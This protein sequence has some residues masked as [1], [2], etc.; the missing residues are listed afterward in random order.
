M[1]RRTIPFTQDAVRRAIL[2]V[3]SAGVDIRS[4]SVLPDGTVVI[5][6][7]NGDTSVDEIDGATAPENLDNIDSY[8]GWRNRSA[9]RDGA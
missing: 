4:V 9:G 8:F 5:N 7:E 2:G 1:G 3:K 6:G